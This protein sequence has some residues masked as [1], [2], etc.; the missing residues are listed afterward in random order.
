M[1][2]SSVPHMMVPAPAAPVISSVW[3]IVAAPPALVVLATPVTDAPAAPVS[4]A[5]PAAPVMFAA[6]SWMG[7]LTA[8]LKKMMKKSRKRSRLAAEHRE[9]AKLQETWISLGFS[10]A[11]SVQGI[12]AHLKALQ[13]PVVAHATPTVTTTT[14]AMTVFAKV[15][16]SVLTHFPTLTTPT[17]VDQAAVH[18]PAPQYAVYLPPS[19]SAVL[20]APTVPGVPAVPAVPATQVA[21]AA[22]AALAAPVVPVAPSWMEDLTTILKKMSK[23][24][25]KKVSR[26]R[27]RL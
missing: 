11:P 8:I 21:P 27:L 1:V 23:E 12:L 19:A 20:V 26:R 6:P 22:P 25:L 4:L 10:G 9:A 24:K 3:A 5:A 2:T 14:V 7:D 17:V 16:T 15:P 18:V 13:V